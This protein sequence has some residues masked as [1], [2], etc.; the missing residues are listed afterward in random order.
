VTMISAR[1]LLAI[2]MLACIGCGQTGPLYL[3]GSAPP[4]SPSPG[5][6]AT[7]QGSDEEEDED[8]R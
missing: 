7:S 3:P 5:P 6:A 1:A 2:A 4:G 8:A